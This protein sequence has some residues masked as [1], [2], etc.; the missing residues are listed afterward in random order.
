MPVHKRWHTLFF[1]LLLG[2]AE[3]AVTGCRSGGGVAEPGVM[4]RVNSY[5]VQR[6][7]LDKA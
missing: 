2:I 7:E 1:F 5:N 4:A 6:P 3:L